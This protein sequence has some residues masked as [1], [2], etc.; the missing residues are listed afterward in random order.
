M[1]NPSNLLSERV[2]AI[3]QN[4]ATQLF[5]SHVSLWEILIKVGTGK[6]E[7]RLPVEARLATGDRLY[8]AS[9]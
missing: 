8:S 6:L 1:D 5:L 9:L 2:R 7:L 4:D 3:I